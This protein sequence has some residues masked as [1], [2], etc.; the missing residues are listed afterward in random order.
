MV[1]GCIVVRITVVINPTSR[2][3]NERGV[4]VLDGGVCA[5]H[6]RWRLRKSAT[7]H[8]RERFEVRQR[9]VCKVVLDG[10]GV[11]Q[12]DRRSEVA[13]TAWGVAGAGDGR[14]RTPR[15]SERNEGIR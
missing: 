12:V 6:P 2:I 14:E 1:V 4:V 10:S 7:L 13:E 3:S 8:R 5:T 11:S 15:G 9:R